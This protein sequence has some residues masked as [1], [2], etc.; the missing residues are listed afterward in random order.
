[1]HNSSQGK[2]LSIRC[3]FKVRFVYTIFYNDILKILEKYSE[4][5]K[6][7]IKK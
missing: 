1:M 4:K 3:Y 6:N 2:L 5:A 7:F